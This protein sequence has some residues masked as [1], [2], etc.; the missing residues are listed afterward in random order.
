MVVLA[1]QCE[2]DR[3]E[4][5]A[6][7]ALP[8]IVDL[9]QTQRQS[10]RLGL[11]PGELVEVALVHATTGKPVKG[12]LMP[13][14]TTRQEIRAGRMILA[15]Q[16][17]S[18]D[19]GIVHMRLLP[20]YYNF[21]A[22]DWPRIVYA[23]QEP[24]KLLEGRGDLTV[25]YGKSPRLEVRLNETDIPPTP[26]PPTAAPSPADARA[27]DP[28]EALRV[29]NRAMVNFDAASAMAVL[30]ASNDQEKQA[31]SDWR[32]FEGGMENLKKALVA[33]FDEKA[34]L[35]ILQD[36]DLRLVV[37]AAKDVWTMWPQLLNRPETSEQILKNA[38]VT[39]T[40]DKALVN[41]GMPEPL[42]LVLRN[43]VWKIEIGGLLKVAKG[44]PQEFAAYHADTLRKTALVRAL[45]KN[46][47]A[48]KF[49]T[50]DEADTRIRVDFGWAVARAEI[51][52]SP[53]EKRYIRI[54]DNLAQKKDL[55]AKMDH[56]NREYQ[57]AYRKATAAI[58]VEKGKV[59]N[60]VLAQYVSKLQTMEANIVSEATS[61]QKT[62]ILVLWKQI[63]DAVAE[64]RK[65]HGLTADLPIDLPPI[66]VDAANPGI[67]QEV[68]RKRMVLELDD[69]M[70][71]EV[72]ELINHNYAKEKAAAS[73]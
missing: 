73:N 49:K 2:E 31:L 43:G 21:Q 59:D 51:P 61:V 47:E 72:I 37:F 60:A 38:K 62:F 7:V 14:T 16:I 64:V 25:E 42:P 1:E 39:I 53:L 26:R 28:V 58:E 55:V 40:G 70:E 19:Q 69:E 33:R 6:W 56:M 22:T 57:E 48:G 13:G 10:V 45:C 67:L 46:I 44:G 12:R 66:P 41:L 17:L 3:V 52:Q 27:K 20:G 8:L 36:I 50:L 24:P 4:P 71:K 15:P 18:D 63:E 30:D 65:K 29:Y 5:G 68:I 9:T 23:D 34:V 35:I 32:D 11:S 54:F